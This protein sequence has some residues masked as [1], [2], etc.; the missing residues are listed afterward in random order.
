[1]IKDIGSSE[2]RV[3]IEIG[4]ERNKWAWCVSYWKQLGAKG[5]RETNK[6]LVDMLRDEVGV[7]RSRGYNILMSGDLNAHIEEMGPSWKGKDYNGKLLQNLCLAY[8][9]SFT[10]HMDVE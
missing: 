1:M 6:N 5:A 10:H 7:L 8:N 3:W 4:K 2:L 9:L